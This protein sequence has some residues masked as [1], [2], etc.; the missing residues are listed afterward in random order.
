[1]RAWG[2]KFQPFEQACCGRD[3]VEQSRGYR[4]IPH[5]CLS[6]RRSVP[7]RYGQKRSA[8]PT[9][10]FNLIRAD[11][12]NGNQSSHHS[13]VGSLSSGQ[14]RGSCRPLLPSLS[15]RDFHRLAKRSQAR[16][17]LPAGT[18]FKKTVKLGLGDPFRF[19]QPPGVVPREA[20]VRKND[21]QRAISEP[22]EH[23]GVGL[24]K[25][26][27]TSRPMQAINLT[28]RLEDGF[29]Q[30]PQLVIVRLEV[31]TP[32]SQP[33]VEINDGQGLWL[34]VLGPGHLQ[35]PLPTAGTLGP[36]SP[37]PHH[38]RLQVDDTRLNDTRETGPNAAD[39]RFILPTL[40]PQARP[41][42]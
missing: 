39:V 19:P 28:N 31:R 27:S 15:A 3:L 16:H 36:T 42:R 41:F 9:P 25:S 10:S 18:L 30:L 11:Q 32:R 33:L 7:P 38:W 29:I 34:L 12:R 4:L 17:V 2:G 1:M 5:R 22:T 21:L 6:V 20:H 26:Q 8:R 14:G 23:H 35:S 24:D 13:Y 37:I 40:E